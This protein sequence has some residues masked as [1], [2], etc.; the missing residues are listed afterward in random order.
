MS[1]ILILP[2]GNIFDKME[3]VSKNYTLTEEMWIFTC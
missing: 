2:Y 1:E 3:S